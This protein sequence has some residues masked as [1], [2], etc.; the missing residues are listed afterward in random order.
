[1]DNLVEGIDYIVCP[2]CKRKFKKLTGG[3]LRTHGLDIKSFRELFGNIPT[4]CKKHIEKKSTKEREI[5]S[6]DSFRKHRSE[7]AKA[8]WENEDIRT[9]KS[10]ITVL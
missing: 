1:M 4:E 3:H 2:V 7:Y 8:L 6:K 10:F 5:M 9:F